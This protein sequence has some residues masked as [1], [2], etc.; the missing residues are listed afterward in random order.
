MDILFENAYERTPAVMKEL[1][2]LIYFKRPVNLMIYVVL[3]GIAV[4]NIITAVVG[5]EYS[6]SGSAYILIFALMQFVMYKNSVSTAISRDKEKFGPE[7][8]KVRTV[9]TE[10]EIQCTYG[11]KT[12]DP[13]PLT[14]IKKVWQTKNLI[15]LHTKARL[16]IIID[17]KGFAVGSQDGFL[18]Y[19]RSNGLKV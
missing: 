13:I 4:A 7:P 15:L 10:E 14:D 16:M 11:E 2:R 3:G 5:G 9:V 8:L 1:Y 12:V 18:E 17:R 19:L 6:F